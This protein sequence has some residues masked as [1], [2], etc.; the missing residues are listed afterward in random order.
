[1][2]ETDKTEENNPGKKLEDRVSNRSRRPSSPAFRKFMA[3][4]WAPRTQAAFPTSGAKPHLSARHSA[5]A[6]KVQGE[7]IAIP[8]GDLKTRVADTDHRFRADSSFIYLSGLWAELEPGA[9]LVLYPAEKPGED[10][11]VVLYFTPRASRS[12]EEFY[13]D[14][15]HGE[16]W[17]GARPSLEEMTEATGLET[18]DLANL[19]G[20]LRQAARTSEVRTIRNVD[21][22]FTELMDEVRGDVRGQA[23][24]D[25]EAQDAALVEVLAHLRVAKDTYEIDQIRK[26]TE[27]TKNGFERVIA[28]LPQAVNHPRGE[29]VLEAAFASAA[30]ELGNGTSFD[31]IAAA[32]NNANT[33][34][35]TDNSGT[36][37][38]G[39]LVLVDA[40]IELDSL[41]SADITRTLPVSGLF[42]KP[43]KKIYQAVLDALEAGFAAAGKPGA[44]F[45]DVHDAAQGVLAA[46][47]EE[48]GLLPVQVK[49]ALKPSGQQHRRWMPHGTSHHLGLDVHDCS[50]LPPEDYHDAPLSP[51][52]VFTIEP[53]LYFRADDLAVPEEF[54][55]IGVRI[56]DNIYMDTEGKPV[57]VS[58]DIPRTAGAVENWI[59]NVQGA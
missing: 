44:L 45:R 9:A 40:G 35:W 33:L 18:D 23:K 28:A 2:T 47:L 4:E 3:S 29:R 57:R 32:G 8:A 52:M 1:M 55:G 46:R 25:M 14:A 41:Y 11:R 42:T 6:Q 5:L 30:R 48:W 26:A 17:V 20:A 39:D 12:S 51:G 19:R 37:E 59:R 15:R 10:P 36:I 13:A 24:A 56:E 58:E 43:Q 38:E 16:F 49:E 21:A 31:T 22:Q 53:G 7:T 50:A 54:R 27:A 34:H